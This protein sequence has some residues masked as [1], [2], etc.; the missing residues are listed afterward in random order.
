M[1]LYYIFQIAGYQEKIE[2]KIIYSHMVNFNEL[3]TGEMKIS[4][5]SSQ[6]Q[7]QS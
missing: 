6:R 7:Y 3:T 2:K 1:G 4:T 5:T